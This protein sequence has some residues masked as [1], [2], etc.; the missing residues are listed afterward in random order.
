M[1]PRLKPFLQVM[2]NCKTRLRL[3][4]TRR[5]R[6]VGYVVL[7]HSVPIPAYL[8]L[9]HICLPITARVPQ[10][11]ILISPKPAS[12]SFVARTIF[13]TKPKSSTNGGREPALEQFVGDG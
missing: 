13:M 5:I 4:P 12:L 11:L 6:R 10:R 3:G 2:F 1:G 9:N 7:L 8:A